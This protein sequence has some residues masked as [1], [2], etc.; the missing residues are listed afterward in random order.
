MDTTAAMKERSSM[1]RKSDAGKLGKM[2]E[3][4]CRCCLPASDNSFRAVHTID[5]ESNPPLNVEPTGKA[6]RRRQRTASVK[7]PRK[8]SAYSSFDRNRSSRLGSKVQY[9][10][11]HFPPGL[12]VVL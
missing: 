3:K 9:G 11:T 7:S 5:E 2:A 6:L 10:R 8:A 12:M 4:V 1:L